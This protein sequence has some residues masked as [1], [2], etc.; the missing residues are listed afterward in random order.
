MVPR[1]SVDPALAARL[2]RLGD[3]L[4]ARRTTEA[5]RSAGQPSGFGQAVKI[6]SEFVA[7]VIVGAGLGWGIDRILG[8]SPVA[9]IVFLLLGFA[10]GVL[11]VLR[12]EGKIAEVGARTAAGRRSP[13][14][15]GSDG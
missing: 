14:P 15:D 8:T 13:P 6:A 1:S 3:G 4:E 5:V 2:A 12:A 10:A 7:G 9:L 11:N